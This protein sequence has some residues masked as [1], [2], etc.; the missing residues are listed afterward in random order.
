MLT[1]LGELNFGYISDYVDDIWIANDEE[2]LSAMRLIYER[3][4]IV[5]E[6]SSAVTLAAIL[7]NKSIVKGK[8]V[9]VIISGGNV[10]L[11]SFF[12]GYDL[13]Y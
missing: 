12:E 8:K 4:K 9:G 3:M 2:I 13:S 11:D 5:V 6:P 10:D 7:N 1:S